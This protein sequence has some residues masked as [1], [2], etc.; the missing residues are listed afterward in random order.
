MYQNPGQIDDN[1]IIIITLKNNVV[2][3]NTENI[4]HTVD[5]K[6]FGYSIG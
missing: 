3:V 4:Q 2:Y 6:L 1:I 5:Y